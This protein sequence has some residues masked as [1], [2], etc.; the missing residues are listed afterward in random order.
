LIAE[1]WLPAGSSAI[2][3]VVDDL[4]V[5]RVDRAVGKAVK[6]G[7]RSTTVTTTP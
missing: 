2:V 4:Y 1:E 3:V 6:R 7:R 5:D